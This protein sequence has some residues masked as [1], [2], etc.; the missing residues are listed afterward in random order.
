M[1]ATR[2]LVCLLFEVGAIFTAFYLSDASPRPA[3]LDLLS[4]CSYKYVSL[5]LDL[6]AG[7]VFGKTVFWILF[8]T[9]SLST[10]VFMVNTRAHSVE[11]EIAKCVLNCNSSV[12]FSR[13]Q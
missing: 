8:L 6:V 10:A 13:Y 9:L 12:S 5:V 3:L 4:L 7:L 11:N 2:C 1:T